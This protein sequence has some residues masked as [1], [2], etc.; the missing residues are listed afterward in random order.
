M[1][2]D[3]SRADAQFLGSSGKAARTGRLFKGLKGV[4]GQTVAHHLSAGA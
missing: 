3:C 2:A 4:Q 1:L